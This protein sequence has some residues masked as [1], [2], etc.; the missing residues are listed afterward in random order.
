MDMPSGPQFGNP[1]LK[2]RKGKFF[3]LPLPTHPHPRLQFCPLPFALM[4]RR[5]VI[6]ISILGNICGLLGL[7]F[8][9]YIFRASSSGSCN[10]STRS[11][12]SK[13]CRSWGVG[14]KIK[15]EHELAQKGLTT[16]GK[17]TTLK[18]PHSV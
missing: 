4:L 10:L 14:R 2:G 11:G 5:S 8:L 1:W 3:F 17:H 18:I 15:V 7:R 12:C 16:Q 6:F 9:T 13:S